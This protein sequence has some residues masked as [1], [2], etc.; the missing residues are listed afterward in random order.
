MHVLGLQ[1]YLCFLNGSDSWKGNLD[2]E[3]GHEQFGE[4]GVQIEISRQTQPFS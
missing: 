2:H 4:A 3:K 1:T